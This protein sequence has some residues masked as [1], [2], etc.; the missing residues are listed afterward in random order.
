MSWSDRP[1][2]ASDSLEAV[3]DKIRETRELMDVLKE[4]IDHGQERAGDL[5]NW[6]KLNQRYESLVTYYRAQM[7]DQEKRSSEQTVAEFWDKER[8]RLERKLLRQYGGK[9]EQYQVLCS[10]LA[11]LATKLQQSYSGGIYLSTNEQNQIATTIQA[12]I[13]QL[14]RHTESTKTETYAETKQAILGVLN[15]VERHLPGQ[16]RTMEGIVGEVK[17]AILAAPH[18]DETDE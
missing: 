5:Q 7:A 17:R 15:I 16:T 10:A 3:Y 14:Q 4:R 9:G 18:H 2:P 1:T 8:E 6:T 12:L 13:A 11:P